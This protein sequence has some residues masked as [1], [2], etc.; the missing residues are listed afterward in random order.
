ME[1]NE[2]KEQVNK[3]D[4]KGTFFLNLKQ[5]KNK[6]KQNEINQSNQ[7]Y[8]TQMKTLVNHPAASAITIAGLLYSGF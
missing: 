4:Q 1:G 8:C 5:S 2:R 6:G 7:I 3:M